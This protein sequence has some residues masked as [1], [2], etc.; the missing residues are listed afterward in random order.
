MKNAETMTR[1]SK[2]VWRW[3]RQWGNRTL[4]E[5]AAE[6]CV[7]PSIILLWKPDLPDAA[8]KIFER[9][10]TTALAV[11]EYTVLSLHAKI[12]E[13]A[14]SNEFLSRKIKPW[15]GR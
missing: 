8:A 1:V 13:L 4:S 2:P 9:G 10:G 15:I 6:N 12:G 11:D 7:H 5:L 14:I 3:K